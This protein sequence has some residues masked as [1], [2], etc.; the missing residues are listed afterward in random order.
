MF[1]LYIA[2]NNISCCVRY[3]KCYL[4]FNF[5]FSV[6]VLD[7]NS[8]TFMRKKMERITIK[9][10]TYFYKQTTHA[11]Y[12]SCVH[13]FENFLN[14]DYRCLVCLFSLKYYIIMMLK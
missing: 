8:L 12:V 11:L 4:Y 3:K 5:S 10:L 9:S 13:E 6:A 14:C 2:Y 7:H 1:T